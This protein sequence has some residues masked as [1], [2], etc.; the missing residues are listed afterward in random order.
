MLR[1]RGFDAVAVATSDDAIAS[2]AT[3]AGA[4]VFEETVQRSHSD[5]ADAAARRAAGLGA[6]TIALLPIDLPLVRP[7]EIE[8]IITPPLEGLVIVPSRDGTGTNALVRTPP[9]TIESRF[10]PGSL[11]A[12]LQQA[13]DKQL[14]TRVLWPAGIVFDLDTPEDWAELRQRGFAATT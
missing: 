14:T 12:H 13:I 2:E 4:L 6:T 9:G 3:R 5:S 11:K 7:E 8:S 1:V 10:G